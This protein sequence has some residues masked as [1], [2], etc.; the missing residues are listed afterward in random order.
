MAGGM[1]VAGLYKKTMIEIAMFVCGELLLEKLT[2][3]LIWATDCS[4]I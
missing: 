4:Y 3:G 1:L 2:S